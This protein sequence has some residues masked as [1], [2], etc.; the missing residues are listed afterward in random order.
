MREKTR[1]TEDKTARDSQ[2]YH[3][4]FSSVQAWRLSVILI[5]M[6]RQEVDAEVSAEVAPD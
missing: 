5:V 6:H 2:G 3:L 4:L 1:D